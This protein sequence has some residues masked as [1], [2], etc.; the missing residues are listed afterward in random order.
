MKAWTLRALHHELWRLGFKMWA[1]EAASGLG[2]RVGK[3]LQAPTL[4]PKTLQSSKSSAQPSQP[5]L[6]S[7]VV[8]QEVQAVEN[9]PSDI[10]Y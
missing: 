2:F 6:N 1:S 9:P 4:K 5:S 8:L 3:A 7:K 10:Q